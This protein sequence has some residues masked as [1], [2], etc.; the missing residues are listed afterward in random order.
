MRYNGRMGGGDQYGE[1][2][3]QVE[4][5][6]PF[7]GE[8]EYPEDVPL[9]EDVLGNALDKLTAAESAARI[10]RM[11]AG[12]DFD[13][14]QLNEYLD[15]VPRLRRHAEW[16]KDT[17]KRK[18]SEL[19]DAANAHANENAA[20]AINNVAS[21]VDR[22]LLS[23]YK[24]IGAAENPEVVNR[25]L[26]HTN[27]IEFL[28]MPKILAGLVKNVGF[29][30]PGV[31]LVFIKSNPKIP[32]EII[33]DYLIHEIIHAYVQRISIGNVV[34][35]ALKTTRGKP[36]L[37]EGLTQYITNKTIQEAL[38]S[39][40]P[41]ELF[42]VK[43]TYEPH[44][45]LAGI[46]MDIDKDAF[47]DWYVLEISTDEFK[48]RLSLSLQTK[49]HRTEAEAK[50]AVVKIFAL[51]ETLDDLRA[52]YIKENLNRKK[53]FKKRL[54]AFLANL[55]KSLHFNSEDP[56]GTQ[57]AEKIL[58]RVFS[59]E[60]INDLLAEEFKDDMLGQEKTHADLMRFY[61]DNIVV[62]INDDPFF[63]N[64]RREICGTI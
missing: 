48:E 45:K 27:E 38:G 61:L 63:E 37:W 18:L 55:L 60:A 23:L 35:A 16:F 31:D 30:V 62:M 7:E 49:Y 34:E 39:D 57:R 59:G 4:Q 44:R 22:L 64:L 43:E 15:R 36:P 26:K 21:N 51:N 19:A 47:M 33:Q 12:Q 56:D 40:T 3:N 42:R 8:P 2:Q 14:L 52:D 6:A 54:A 50:W 5:A 24:T 17:L 11:S 9:N 20:Q 41:F 58:K 32:I 29:T 28:F 53:E 25:L 1:K 10:E 46:V 13:E